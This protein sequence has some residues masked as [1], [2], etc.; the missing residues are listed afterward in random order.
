MSTN[1]LE[2]AILRKMVQ[3]IKQGIMH[4]RVKERLRLRRNYF[5]HLR[6]MND[7]LQ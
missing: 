2:K 6:L 7:K 3:K 5:E 1:L 4:D